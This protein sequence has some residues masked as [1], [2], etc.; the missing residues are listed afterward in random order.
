MKITHHI[1]TSKERQAH[2]LK[3]FIC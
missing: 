1:G 3:I 2:Q